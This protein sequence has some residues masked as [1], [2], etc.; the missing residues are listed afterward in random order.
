[1]KIVSYEFPKSSFLSVDKDLGTIS[2]MI[3]KNDVIQKLLFYTTENALDKPKLTDDERLS[4]IN[5]NIKIV[6]KVTV[7]ETALTYVIISMDN[8]TPS[9]NPE[10]R[11]NVITFDILCHF[12]Y[13][14]LHDFQ[15]R[16]YRIA[17]EL[18]SMFNNRKLSGIGTL[19]FLGA[20]QIILS[21]EF[22]G[23]T[24]MYETT[25]GEED[26]KYLPNP[27]DEDQFLENFNKVFNGVE[28]NEGN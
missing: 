26:K 6:P 22:G 28:P 18:D 4:L 25:H 5:K 12:N 24:L 7:D 21:D 17:A 27:N 8:F 19:N 3:L 20:S 10:F 2:N 16:P 9:G 11:N 1:M 23:L 13:W 15:L 14:Q